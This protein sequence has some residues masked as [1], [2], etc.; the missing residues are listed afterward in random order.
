MS[1]RGTRRDNRRCDASRPRRRART[2]RAELPRSRPRGETRL[3]GSHSDPA[4][5][6]QF[7]AQR[8]RAARSCE[9]CNRSLAT[10]RK[11]GTVRITVT[12]AG[13]GI[14]GPIIKSNP[15]PL[16][17]A[18]GDAVPASTRP[19]AELRTG[20]R[21]SAA[22]IGSSAAAA[23]FTSSVPGRSTLR[24][25]SQARVAT[26]SPA[27]PAPAAV[28][29]V[30]R[31]RVPPVSAAP[32]F[33]SPAPRSRKPSETQ[34]VPPARV[35]PAQPS[36]RSGTTACSFL[37]SASTTRAEDVGSAVEAPGGHAGRF[38]RACRTD[39]RLGDRRLVRR[40]LRTLP[41]R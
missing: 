4:G 32:P 3:G 33:A 15:V 35:K 21:A 41:D 40:A 7:D 24:V 34:Q 17:A 18:A 23:M 11:G 36:R 22:E 12:G 27:A 13:S 1:H 31:P 30:S 9:V 37:L 20:A 39:N 19:V 6:R 29:A 14:D 38:G 2:R 26:S 16:V 10:I 25:V 8:R 5:H 28:P